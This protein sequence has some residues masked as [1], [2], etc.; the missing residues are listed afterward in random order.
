MKVLL[1]IVLPT[2]ALIASASAQPSSASCSAF[3]DPVQSQP[4]PTYYS[5]TITTIGAA[6]NT[7]YNLWLS[8][9]GNNQI[10]QQ[11]PSGF[12]ITDDTGMGSL[13]VNGNDP[14]HYLQ[15][16]AVSVKITAYTG[17]ARLTT[18][19]FQVT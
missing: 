9:K 1:V 14:T 6:P 5:T 15:P 12:F 13:P 11:H 17:G 16:G 4:Y 3:P 18:C 2:L 10:T 19:S 8:E 7:Y